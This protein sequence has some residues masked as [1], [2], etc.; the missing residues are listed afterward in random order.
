[1][2][3]E[4][5]VKD[6]RFAR[7]LIHPADLPHS[8]P[9]REAP[10]I[11]DNLP[12]QRVL[13]STEGQYS[14]NLFAAN[15]QL[16]AG[17]EPSAP[18]WVQKLAV[19][20]IYSGQNAGAQDGPIS[21][22]WLKAFGCGAIVVAGKDS[23][24]YFHAVA[25]PDKF[26]GLVPRVWRDSGDSIYQVPQRSTSLAHVIPGSAVVRSQPINGLDVGELRRYVDALESPAMPPASIVWEKP[27]HARII[28][29]LD[30]SEVLTVQETYDPGW[31]ARVGNR[32]VKVSADKLGF[33]LME[34]ECSECSI[35]LEFKGGRERH[36]TA[37]ASMLALLGL[38]A[39]LFRRTHRHTHH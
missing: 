11:A 23:K 16:S 25:N 1:M 22:L 15:P 26:E 37:V 33:I 8:L 21:V 3:T 30:P 6:W 24:D 4:A 9:Y 7:E 34:P 38:V 28:A 5:A 19:Y 20:T 39:M 29:K 27:D 2:N 17:H 32:R 13:V 31:E 18:N 36:V 14:F 35:D 10:W 12:G